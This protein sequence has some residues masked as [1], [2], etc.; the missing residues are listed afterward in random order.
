MGIVNANKQPTALAA[1]ALLLLG[2]SLGGCATSTAGSSLMEA[3]AHA[4][5][6]LTQ[7]AYSQVEALPPESEGQSLWS[8]FVSV[9]VFSA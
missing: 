5:A 9:L 1:G 2:L 4:P 8:P 6:P 7:S 3:R